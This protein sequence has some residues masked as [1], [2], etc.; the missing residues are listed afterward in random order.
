MKPSITGN[1]PNSLL[2]S[3]FVCQIAVAP[4]RNAEGQVRLYILTFRAASDFDLARN[5]I[6][7]S[8]KVPSTWASQ[9]PR[10]LGLTRILTLIGGRQRS[11]VSSS[12]AASGVLDES[13]ESTNDE[14]TRYP[15]VIHTDRSTEHP[16]SNA[17]I[18]R[19]SSAEVHPNVLAEN[20][21]SVDSC[22]ATTSHGPLSVVSTP[23]SAI[24]RPSGTGKR[25]RRFF[26]NKT[27]SMFIGSAFNFRLDSSVE[28]GAGGIVINTDSGAQS[29]RNVSDKVAEMLSLGPDVN[30]EQKLHAP[31][32]HPFTLKHYGPVK[33]VWDWLVLVLVIYTAIFT[34][35]TAAFLLQEAK[36]RRR[37]HVSV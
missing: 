32:T 2:G 34:P 15:L 6:H 36:L 14:S 5:S 19:H 4:V 30:P 11:S 29:K 12:K 20:T 13:D 37:Y 28:H 7:G 8:Y 10:L 25:A 1:F 18:R 23:S 26:L 35:F 21:R 22:E 9:L 31:R 3:H 16:S 17:V 33:A 27:N 24:R